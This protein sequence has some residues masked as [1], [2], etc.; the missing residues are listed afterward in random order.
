[1]NTNTQ[2]AEKLMPTK[3]TINIKKQIVSGTFHAAAVVARVALGSFAAEEKK[4]SV[5][6]SVLTGYWCIH[7]QQRWTEHN[8]TEWFR[9]VAEFSHI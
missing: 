5:E 6:T 3:N 8:Y 7:L 2:S 4:R 1:M 9:S